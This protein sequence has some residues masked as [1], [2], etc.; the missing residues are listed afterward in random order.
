MY[1]HTVL[2]NQ[3]YTEQMEWAKHTE[4]Y[5]HNVEGIAYILKCVMWAGIS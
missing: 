3:Q 5:S 1:M 4:Q 2:Y